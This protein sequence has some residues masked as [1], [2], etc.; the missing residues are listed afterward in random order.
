M[1]FALRV[2]R[3]A[4]LN[5]LNQLA[6]SPC[7]EGVLTKA[8]LSFGLYHARQ[9]ITHVLHLVSTRKEYISCM[10]DKQRSSLRPTKEGGIEEIL[11]CLSA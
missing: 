10:I 9:Q 4:L 11:S 3:T 7:L 8:D 5:G 1:S 2:P 6:Y